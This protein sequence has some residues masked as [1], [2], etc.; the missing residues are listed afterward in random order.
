MSLPLFPG[1]S[2]GLSE[3]AMEENILRDD[4]S[5]TATTGESDGRGGGSEGGSEC[6]GKK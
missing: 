3:E 4:F 2:L 6:E 5:S 1:N